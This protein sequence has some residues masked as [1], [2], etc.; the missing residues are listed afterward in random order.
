MG[1]I[2]KAFT[3]KTDFYSPVVTIYCLNTTGRA[4]AMRTMLTINEIVMKSN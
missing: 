2:T 4:I 1:T 3:D